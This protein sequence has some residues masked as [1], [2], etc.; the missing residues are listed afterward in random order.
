[1]RIHLVHNY[2][3]GQLLNTNTYHSGSTEHAI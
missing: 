1:L 3:V 2:E